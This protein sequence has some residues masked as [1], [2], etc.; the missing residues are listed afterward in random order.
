[1]I[2]TTLLCMWPSTSRWSFART[3]YC[4][5]PMGHPSTQEHISWWEHDPDLPS[6]MGQSQPAWEGPWMTAEQAVIEGRHPT[7]YYFKQHGCSCVWRASDH[8]RTLIRDAYD[9]TCTFH[10]PDDQL[11]GEKLIPL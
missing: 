7:L 5:L 8:A 9:P 11:P 3:F 1:M 10:R 2:D 4:S 6:E